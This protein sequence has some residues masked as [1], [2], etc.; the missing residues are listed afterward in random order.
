MFRFAALVMIVALVA[1]GVS[2]AR[3][4]QTFLS[5]RWLESRLETALQPLADN[6][7]AGATLRFAIEPT[8][9]DEPLV[10]KIRQRVDVPKIEWADADF[11]FAG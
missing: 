10:R 7:P 1:I 3:P 11:R 5:E 8:A 2:L 9:R 6:A 4:D